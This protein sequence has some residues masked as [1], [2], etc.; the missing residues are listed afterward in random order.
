[1][2]LV[3]GRPPHPNLLPSGRRNTSSPRG[4]RTEVRGK[5]SHQSMVD[6]ALY[7][8]LGIGSGL[9]RNQYSI[10]CDERKVG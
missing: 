5:G 3:P 2:F 1:M 10:L 6:M 9:L 7:G 4:E 8:I